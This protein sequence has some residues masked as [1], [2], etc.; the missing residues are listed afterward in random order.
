M[1][2]V[3]ELSMVTPPST[4]KYYFKD[5]FRTVWKYLPWKKY[6]KPLARAKFQNYLVPELLNSTHAEG[7][8]FPGRFKNCVKSLSVPERLKTVPLYIFL[9]FSSWKFSTVMQ[10]V[11]LREHLL[12][13]SHISI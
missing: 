10:L 2:C 4:R 9:S 13:L 12:F 7:G 6:Q 5:L 8:T 11:E 3:Y 1:K